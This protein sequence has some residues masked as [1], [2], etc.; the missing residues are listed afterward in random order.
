MTQYEL[1]NGELTFSRSD[2]LSRVCS[3]HRGSIVYLAGSMVEGNGNKQSDVD[4]YVFESSL[5]SASEVPVHNFALN[6]GDRN[7]LHYTFLNDE[8]TGFDV[9]YYCTSEFEEMTRELDEFYAASL[10][11]TRMIR[12]GMKKSTVD[13]LARISCGEF[14]SGAEDLS[15]RI[16]LGK[17]C[18]ALY[19]CSAGAFHEFKDVVGAWDAG[20]LELASWML[21]EV[22]AIE[23]MGLLHLS[24]NPSCRRKWLTMNLFKMEGSASELGKRCAKWLLTAQPT[25]CDIQVGCRLLD[26]IYDATRGMLDATAGAYEE[27]EA[28]QLFLDE[29]QDEPKKDGGTNFEFIYRSRMVFPSVGSSWDFLTNSKS[30]REWPRPVAEALSGVRGQ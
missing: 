13:V 18:F 1:L 22:I 6:E 27:A 10:T 28:R 3:S 30:R 25:E 9:E 23:A 16:D 4:L 24:G 29:Y 5:P 26:G 7:R 12:T 11:S 20:D 17:L 14:V 8:G 15:T 2:L 19:R 21:R